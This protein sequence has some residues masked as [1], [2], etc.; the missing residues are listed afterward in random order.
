MAETLCEKEAVKE[1]EN[2]PLQICFVCTGNTCRSPMAA[3]VANA[4]AKEEIAGI[5]EDMK[6]LATLRL[7]AFSAGLGAREGDPMAENAKSALQ[8]AGFT[9][10]SHTAHTLTEEEAKGYDYLVGMTSSHVM[11]LL[12][13]FPAMASKILRMPEEISDPFLC[14]LSVYRVCLA[15]IEKGVR[16]LFFADGVQK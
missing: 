1:K 13:S 12:Y 4:L 3:A 14:D 2:R 7:E 5:P 6:K 8:E 10:P 16:T 15:E 9:V 11:Q